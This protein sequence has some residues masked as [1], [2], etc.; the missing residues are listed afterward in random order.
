MLKVVVYWVYLFGL[1][2]MTDRVNRCRAY[3]RK[4]YFK[5]I[6]RSMQIESVMLL[7]YA[8]EMK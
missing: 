1:N 8:I 7:V 6:I 5:S 3:M 2:F 4:F